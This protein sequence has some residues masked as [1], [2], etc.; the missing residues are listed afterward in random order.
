MERCEAVNPANGVQCGLPED[1]EGKRANG[2]LTPTW[3]DMP[4]EEFMKTMCPKCFHGRRD[5]C[6]HIGAKK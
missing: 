4:H 2:T 6:C 1:H 3:E 5:C